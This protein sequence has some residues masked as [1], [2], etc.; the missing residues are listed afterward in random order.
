M[1]DL[2]V[3]GNPSNDSLEKK[4]IS[5][6]TLLVSVWKNSYTL[7]LCKVRINYDRSL[8]QDCSWTRA[9][10]HVR[11][12]LYESTQHGSIMELQKCLQV[13][14]LTLC[15]HFISRS[16][17]T[18]KHLYLQYPFLLMV[19]QGKFSI[20]AFLWN[21]IGQKLMHYKLQCQRLKHDPVLHV[22]CR[23]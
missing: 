19:C 23:L 11:L 3:I 17:K 12:G 16:W 4:K 15:N 2:I 13:V 9:F 20:H 14:N 8:K 5:R 6:F 22:R 1:E 10:K 18:S 21:H 7:E